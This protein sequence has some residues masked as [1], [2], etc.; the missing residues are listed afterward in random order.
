MILTSCDQKHQKEEH[1]LTNDLSQNHDL[2]NN[3]NFSPDDKW[4]VYDT[5]TEEGGIGANGKIEK[6]HIETG[7]KKV[8]YHLKQ[9]TPYGPG[10][11]AVSYNP[12][13]N[14][15]IFIH[16]LKNASPD[17]PYEQWR[18]S[19]VIVKD[20][21]PNHPIYM[22]ARDTA[23]PFTPG[24]LRGGTHRHEFSGDGQW[25]GFTYNDAIMKK[26]EDDSGLLHNLRTIGVSKKDT[27]VL[28]PQPNWEEDFSGEWFSVVVVTVVPNPVPGSDQISRAAGDSWIGYSGYQ[29][30]NGSLQ[31]ARAFIGTV[32]NEK[33][34]DIDE[35]FVV[36]IPENISIPGDA[37]LEGTTTTMPAPPRGTVQRRLTFTSESDYP[38]CEGIVRSSFDGSLLAFIARDNQNIKQVFTIPPTGGSAAQQTFHP[39]DVTGG[40]RWHPTNQS[41]IYI[42]DNTLI[43]LKIGEKE[44]QVLTKPSPLT[45]T[46]PV[47]S[48]NGKILAYNRNLPQQEGITTKQ[49]FL[50]HF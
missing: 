14:E 32:K 30:T 49:I 18:R 37:P 24:A 21:K 6:V 17:Y 13:E 1:Q 46:N 11:G 27:P 50:I 29:K 31:R 42:W 9:N 39:S 36:D 38:G 35:V 34:K 7:E 2:D 28:V 25:V 41:L 44:G 48:H 10:V 40:I 20:N 47:W 8:L 12:T 26:M 5:R 16:G 4:L 15:V 3:D 45:I 19:G 22:D 23:V 33:G 43:H